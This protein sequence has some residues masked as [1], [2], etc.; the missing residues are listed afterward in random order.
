MTHS[1]HIRRNGDLCQVVWSSKVLHNHTHAIPP[2]TRRR[3]A[4][5]SHPSRGATAAAGVMLIFW[6]L[7]VS[8]SFARPIVPK[9]GFLVEPNGERRHKKI[10]WL[11]ETG[12]CGSPGF[13]PQ[14]LV[15]LFLA[16]ICALYTC[17]PRSAA[18]LMMYLAWSMR[19]RSSTE[20]QC[21]ASWPCWAD[22][23]AEGSEPWNL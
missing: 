4:A 22:V 13:E 18:H 6:P 23:K 10:S 5:V 8:Q 3:F 19:G 20:H 16:R 12:E 1:Y 7:P 15:P 14:C 2:A 9:R 17:T 11:P 21:A